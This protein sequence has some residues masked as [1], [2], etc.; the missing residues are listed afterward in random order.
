MYNT[1]NLA[2][3]KITSRS[4]LKPA[5]QCVAFYG[6]RTV[7]TD[8][9]RMIEVSAKGEPHGIQLCTAAVIP[10]L[11]KRETRAEIP[12]FS[13]AQTS[14]YPDVDQVFDAQFSDEGKEYVTVNINGHYLAEVAKILADVSPFGRIVLQ[15]ETSG[16]AKH[17][18][19][20]T[21]NDARVK[22]FTENVTQEARA[23]VM[24]MNV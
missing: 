15:V 17:A 7:A 21:S 23:L 10:K 12:M 3:A 6:N 1:H 18:V 4:D 11:K 5:L 22:P 24:P 14:E 8:S 9:F 19:R 13:I 2:I 20:I 16:H